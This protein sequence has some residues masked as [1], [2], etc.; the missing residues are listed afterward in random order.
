MVPGG[1]VFL[2]SALDISGFLV[3]MR[4]NSPLMPF[5]KRMLDP[6]SQHVIAD[7]DLHWQFDSAGAA[8]DKLRSV[9]SLA[10]FPMRT[11]TALAD[12]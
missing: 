5:V 11:G 6:V 9:R 12:Q 10:D 7:F 2:D 3:H 1:H 4:M 8:Q